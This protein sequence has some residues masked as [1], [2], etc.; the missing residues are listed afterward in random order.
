MQLCDN[1][2]L[3]Q[4]QHA[5]KGTT[6]IDQGRHQE[7]N[8]FH[9]TISLPHRLLLDERRI[10]RIETAKN[11]KDIVILPADKGRITV[12]MDKKDYTDKMDSLAS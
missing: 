1:D 4:L 5:E 12:V 8:S 10:K 6:S 11:D 2:A 9:S 7:Q 3:T